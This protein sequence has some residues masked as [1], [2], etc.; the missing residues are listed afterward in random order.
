MQFCKKNLIRFTNLSLLRII[1]NKEW[2]KNFGGLCPWIKNFRAKTTKSIPKCW[3]RSVKRKSNLNFIKV[4]KSSSEQLFLYII[5]ALSTCTAAVQ[6]FQNAICTAVFSHLL[7]R[8]FLSCV[9]GRC[10]VINSH[11]LQILRFATVKFKITLLDFL[12][13]CITNI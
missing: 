1:M 8:G 9:Q 6:N 7:P 5:Y 4:K 11:F 13:L 2:I 10:D 3:E 12:Y